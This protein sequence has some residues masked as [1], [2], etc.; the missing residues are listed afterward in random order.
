M[1]KSETP[2]SKTPNPADSKED[3]A[4]GEHAG[5]AQAGSEPE[6]SEEEKPQERRGRSF[7]TEIAVL[8][9]I[10]LTIA[11]L[12]KSFVVQPFFIPSGSMENTLLV[13]DKVLVNKL[14]YD[15]RPI[16]RG[17]IIVFNGDGSWNP[18]ASSQGGHQSVIARVYDDTLGALF[19]N[20]GG[21]FGTPTDQ[22][23][24]IKRVIGLPGDHV[25]CCNAKGQITVNGVALNE[26]SYL[27]PGN[28][29]SQYPFNVVVPAGQLW[30]MGDHRGD[31]ADSRYHDCAYSQREFCV[32]YD[33]LGTVPESKV[34]GRAFMIIWPP[35]RFRILP[36]PATFEQAKL[37]ESATRTS[38]A[39][40]R[41]AQRLARLVSYGAG[42]PVK[43]SAPYLPL[44]LGFGLAFPLTAAERLMRIRFLARRR[45]H[46]TRSRTR[47]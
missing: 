12:I 31:S 17:D 7:L 38:A 28:R 20:I 14:V 45:R 34:I 44:A 21:L 10:A 29:P 27:H 13:G 32:P 23:D 33:R 16:Q 4:A 46:R 37:L 19:S 2:P 30:V 24:Y 5:G 36:I 15:V 40:D 1:T 6:A 18:P 42:L 26:S 9:V 25:I 3:Q 35:S 22:I 8:F 11:L 43:P 47:V 41:A 39:G